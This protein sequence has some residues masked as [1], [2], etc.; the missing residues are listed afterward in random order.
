VVQEAQLLVTKWNHEV[1]D[2]QDCYTWLLYFSISKILQLHELIYTSEE[3]KVDDKI[4]HEVSFLM[5]GQAEEREKIQTKIEV[6]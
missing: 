3:E 4:V 1:S 2:L 5:S 6:S